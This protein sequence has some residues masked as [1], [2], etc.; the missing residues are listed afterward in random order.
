MIAAPITTITGLTAKPAV[1]GDITGTSLQGYVVATRREFE[2]A[3]GKPDNGD[4]EKVTTDWMIIIE[5]DRGT[6]VPVTIY[7]WK[8]G[9]APTSD[10]VY[11]WHIGGH[12]PAAVEYLYRYLWEARYGN[13]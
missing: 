13:E 4:G 6:S 1:W 12:S 2:T 3:F 11:E 8:R 10:E 5:D 7:D 9:V